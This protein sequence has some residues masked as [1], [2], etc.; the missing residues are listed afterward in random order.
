MTSFDPEH[1]EVEPFDREYAIEELLPVSI[2]ERLVRDSEILWPEKFCLARLDGAIY[3]HNGPW[4]AEQLKDLTNTLS[5]TVPQN[6]C[7]LTGAFGR[8]LLIFP[9]LYE[10]EIK[11]YLS[12]PVCRKD[13]ERL[14]AVGAAMVQLLR[15]LIGLKHQTM[16]TSGLHGMVV[17]ESYAQLRE[18]ASQLAISEEKYRQLAANLEIEVHKKTE[19]I[20]IAHAHLVQQEKL[21]AI[22]QLS[23]GVAHEINNPLGFIISNL[24]TL[25]GYASD[26]A[27][28]IGSYRNLSGVHGR[29]ADVDHATPMQQHLSAIQD[30][31]KELDVDFLLTDLPTLAEETIGGAE[32]IQKIVTDLKTVARPGE[33]KPELI[34][35]HQSIDAVLTI[36][37]NR[38]RDGIALRKAYGPIPLVPGVAQELNQ[39]WL[40][41]L[42]NAIEAMEG[43]GTLRI[44]THAERERITV[45]VSDSGRGIAQEHL[46]KIF[47]PFF[48]TKA[49]GHGT[50]L[51]LHLVYHLVQKHNGRIE[52]SSVK[53]RGSTFCVMLSAAGR[54]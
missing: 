39:V 40:N 32:R 19:E 54:S 37:Q 44:A 45:T 53:G 1:I 4:P 16:L 15:M 52:V 51:G 7:R 13:P 29:K 25:K 47:D 28:L 46:S 20:R 6:D 30:L 38:M 48:T 8:E 50:G 34:N 14:A 42:I 3:F 43:R 11:G 21:A 5:T 2:L 33:N 49:V 35:L 23:A 17:E 10:L 27:A 24:S 41:L 9:L 22:G 12:I 18:K 36:L 31:E 26:L